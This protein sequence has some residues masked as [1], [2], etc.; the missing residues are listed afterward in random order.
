MPESSS[1]SKLSE[2]DAKQRHPFLL[3]YISTAA[4]AAVLIFGD[5]VPLSWREGICLL[6]VMIGAFD[7][8][9]FYQLLTLTDE[10]QRDTND[11]ALRFGFLATLVLSLLGGFVRG[12]GSAPQELRAF[13]DC[14]AQ[15]GTRLGEALALKW[16]HID[17]ERRTLR[18]EHSLWR[19]QLVSPR[20]SASARS[21]PLGKALTE[22]LKT[23]REKSFHRGPDDFVFCKRDGSPLDPDVLRKDV[24]YPIVD[25]LGIPRMK[26]ASGFHTFRHSAASIINE[27][28]GHLK[29]AQKFLGHSTI[30][31][32]ADIYTHTSAE[33]EREAA[34]A[35][36]RAIYG[37]LF[38]IV[39]NFAN[40]NN[41]AALN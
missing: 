26:G 22:T 27:Q 6:T 10:R 41:S 30:E 37:E 24:L 19:G 32:T 8:W 15:T 17:L 12:F 13:F 2:I 29:L 35:L 33:A 3:F 21:I 11:Q 7:L 40:G 39:P 31:M 16:K 4:F 9:N 14:V 25:R 28:T 20:T 36:E 5:R 1:E 18:V 38:P 23:H 34:V